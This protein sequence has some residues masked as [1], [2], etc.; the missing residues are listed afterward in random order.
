MD[1][2]E[3][4]SNPLTSALVIAPLGIG[5]TLLVK[6]LRSQRTSIPY[7]QGGLPFF[8]NVFSMIKGSPWDT[9]TEWA[10]QY[11]RI[12]KITLFGSDGIVISDA[13]MLKVVLNTKLSVFKKDVEWT[14][15]PFLVILGNG[16]VTA[17][18]DN[19]R[20]QRVLLSSH[21]RIDI[22]D[23]IP[24]MA[25]RAVQR[26]STKLHKARKSGAAVNMAEE[27]RHLT[28]QV[29]AEAVLSISPEES[30]STFAEMYLPIVEEGNLRTWDPTRAYLPTPAWFAF[31]KAVDRLNSY[32]TGL[33][34]SRWALRQQEEKSGSQGR[35]QDILDK[36]LGAITPDQWNDAA[37]RQVC[38]EV[39]TFILAGHETSASMLTWALLELTQNASYRERV[40]SEAAAVF[41]RGHYSKIEK[42][43]GEVTGHLSVFAAPPR[44][45]L[46]SGL[47]YTEC[48][49]RES[50]RKYSNVPTVVRLSAEDC[51]VG[52]HLI[53][54]GSTIMVNIQ[55]VHHDPE[56]WPRP[57][58]YQPERFLSPITP[59]TFLPFVEG[60]RMCL[61][62]H[63]ALLE[64]KVVLSVLLHTFNFETQNLAE[65]S[66]KHPFMVPIIPKNGHFMTI[67]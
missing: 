27:F 24:D 41:E 48:C 38:D 55:G 29:I 4:T 51:Q 52:P 45:A 15:K 40:R 57:L 9:M 19:W 65:A 28:L 10:R 32:V 42:M 62:Q 25:I 66:V 6:Y 46:D 8:G 54:K 31:R 16:L 60:P 56:Y 18:G 43:D 47:V 36:V 53:P 7:V 20:R 67:S 17:D 22:L 2:K 13:E 12:Y 14:Y 1:L 61:G 11:G 21:L 35:K 37:I 30:D 58:E 49:L 33:I 44:P 59:Y 34:T 63:L 39:K 50:L 23:L 64:S 5:V 26:L 3:L